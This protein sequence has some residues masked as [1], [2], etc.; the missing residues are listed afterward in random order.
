MMYTPLQSGS[1]ASMTNY[2]LYSNENINSL[3]QSYNNQIPFYQPLNF[4]PLPLIPKHDF[5]LTERKNSNNETSVSSNSEGKQNL[6][7]V[8][9]MDDVTTSKNGKIVKLCYC[10]YKNCVKKYKSRENLFFHIQNVH[11][12]QKPYYCKLCKNAFSHRN[13]LNYHLK[14]FH[15]IK[16][17]KRKK[18]VV[19]K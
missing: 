19:T 6:F 13:G 11:L 16:I 18:V 4:S 8:R 9:K 2:I 1:V 14:N 10:T 12:K 7:T 5:L 3:I 15:H 17:E